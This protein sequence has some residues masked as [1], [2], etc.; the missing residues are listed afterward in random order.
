[1]SVAF[2]AMSSRS[3]ASSSLN[4]SELNALVARRAALRSQLA[5][6]EQQL[7]AL[8]STCASSTYSTGS[9][10]V[11]GG[12]PPRHV[13]AGP[14]PPPI[15]MYQTSA[16]S[17]APAAKSAVTRALESKR[18]GSGGGGGVEAR[19]PAAMQPGNYAF[20]PKRLPGAAS[21]SRRARAAAAAPRPPGGGGLVV[22]ARSQP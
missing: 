2:D 11:G 12:V 10:R 19:L 9:P 8:P 17:A 5:T 15:T 16:R 20:W 14:L 3:A 22:A 21:S 18:G 4:G 7:A 6:V 1:M 13:A